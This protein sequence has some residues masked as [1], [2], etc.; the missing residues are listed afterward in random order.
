MATTTPPTRTSELRRVFLALPFLCLSVGAFFSMD[1]VGMVLR[2]SPSAT[3][4]IEWDSGSVNILERFHFL[5]FVDEIFRD[6]TVGFA[7]SSFGFDPSSWWQMVVFLNDAGLLH[8]VWL[9]ESS[10]QG[11]KGTS[12]Y[13]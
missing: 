9:L 3:G 1:M 11:A 10:R 6:V 4:R 5:R 8:L 2:P 7:P 12:V 13:L